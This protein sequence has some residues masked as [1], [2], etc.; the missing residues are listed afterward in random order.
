MKKHLN[1]LEKKVNARK[2]I[3]SIIMDQYFFP[4]V[5]NYIKS[6]SLYASKIHPEEKWGNLSREMKINLIKKTKEIMK[7]SYQAGGAEL[8]DF[9]NP[10]HGGLIVL[11]A[12]Y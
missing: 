7:N 6:E 2:S 5:G 12:A 10:F 3:C 4:G 8:K 9:K 1:Y 11:S